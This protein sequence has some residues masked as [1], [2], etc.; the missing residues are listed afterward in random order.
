MDIGDGPMNTQQTTL[1]ALLVL[2]SG[3]GSGSGYGGMGSAMN[4]TS[5]ETISGPVLPTL[6]TKATIGSTLDPTEHGGNPYGMTL[7]T[8]TA[9]LVTAGDLIVCNF[10]DGASNTEGM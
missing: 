3:C 4:M 1:M 2:L 5:N 6:A 7:A 8:A 9:G 10:N